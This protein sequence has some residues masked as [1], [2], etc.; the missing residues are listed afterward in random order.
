MRASKSLY[1]LL[2]RH[3]ANVHFYGLALPDALVAW[4]SYATPLCM[5]ASSAPKSQGP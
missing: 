4:T 5:A 3:I 1:S 2:Y